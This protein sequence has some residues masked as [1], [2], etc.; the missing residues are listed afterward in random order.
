M[1]LIIKIEDSVFVGAY[2]DGHVDLTIVETDGN[3]NGGEPD[4]AKPDIQNL[5][6]FEMPSWFRN[7]YK[8]GTCGH[9][10]S[11]EWSATCDDDCPACG[12]RHWSP[13]RSD[14]LTP[15]ID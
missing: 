12:A 3:V 14:D 8:C 6:E 9:L 5:D 11:G 1:K 15:S 2:A 10:W 7:H 4:S 13:A